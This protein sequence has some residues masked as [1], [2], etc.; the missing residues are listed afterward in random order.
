VKKK[1]SACLLVL[2]LLLN[3]GCTTELYDRMLI[4]AIGVDLLEDGVKVTVRISR[5]GQ[6]EKEQVV[7]G[8]G[9]SVYLALESIKL[10][11]GKIPLYSHNYLV[12]FGRECCEHG[13]NQVLDF[14][15]RH[16]ESRP[17][18]Q[19]FMAETTAEEVLQVTQNDEL[20]SSGTIESMV[21]EKVSGGAAVRVRV[22]DFLNGRSS[23]G[24][25]ACLPVLA[26]REEVVELTET[27]VFLE[28]KLQ[29][30]LNAEETAGLLAITGQLQGASYALRDEKDAQVSLRISDIKANITLHD[31]VTVRL[32]LRAE[33]AA[34]DGISD[35][36]HRSS[37]ALAAALAE[38]VQQQAQ[39]VL[40]KALREY[41]C[42][43]FG[44]SSRFGERV[45]SDLP[46]QVQAEARVDQVGDEWVPLL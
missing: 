9:A 16:F 7:S 35:Q 33:V 21:E 25:T 22:L 18:V 10:Q 27:A 42:D 15:V 11:T 13:L 37:E 12:I 8:D 32:S 24:G 38:A 23:T 28:D 5:P 41:G 43:I 30:T 20:I 46:V 14:F 45:P 19:L 29:T 34:F 31:G 4:H 17:S 2:L 3:S 6:E 26:A 44:F 40:Q 36:E 1:L 39:A